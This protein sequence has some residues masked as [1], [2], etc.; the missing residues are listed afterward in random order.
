MPDPNDVNTSPGDP[1]DAVIAEYVQQ[2]EAGQIPDREALLARYPELAERLREF[3]ADFDRLDRQAGELRLSADP[4]RT[5][6]VPGPVME[7]QRVRYFGDYELL[8]VIAHGG[9]GVVYKARQMSLN[10]VVALKMILRGELTTERDVARFRAEAEAAA[11]LDHPHIV[12]IYEVGEHDGLQYYSMRYV[13][14]A[15]LA[16][17]PRT[18]SRSEAR[19]LAAVAGAVHHAHRRGVLHRDLKPSNIL[20]NTA[21][22]P[23]VA[24]FGLAKRVDADRSLTE[25][26]VI[27]GTPRYMAPEQAAGRKDLTVAV[28]VY[29][30]GVVLYERLTGHTPFTGETVLELLRQA[31]EEEPPRPSSICPGL[32]RDLE[33]I[34]LKCLE[35]D[36]SKRYGSAEALQDDLERWLRG[37]PIKARPVGQAER[38]WRWCRRNPVVAGLSAGIVVALLAVTGISVALAVQAR[39]LTEKAQQLTEVERE[40]RQRAERSE[41]D[42]QETLARSLIRPL[43]GRDTLS[44]Q[45]AEALW[46]L[47]Q[48]PGERLWLRFLVEA[49]RTPLTTS[50][51]S[52]RAES[53]WIAAVGLDAEKR[54]LVED[55]L[56]Q[57][58]EAADLSENQRLDLARAA[59]TLG[60][61][62]TVISKQMLDILIEGLASKDKSNGHN[63]DVNLLIEFTQRL[64]P[65]TATGILTQVL[66]KETNGNNRYLLTRELATVAGRMESDKA[67]RILTQALEKEK[68][69]HAW[70]RSFLFQ[71]LAEAAERVEPSKAARILIQALE[72][73]TDGSGCLELS[74]SLTNVIKRMELAEAT[75]ISG[76]AASILIQAIEK[77]TNS[78]HRNVLAQGLAK[79][80]GRMEPLEAVRVSRQAVNIFARALEKEPN[81]WGLNSLAVGLA[82]VAARIDSREAERLSGQAAKILTGELEKE[83]NAEARQDLARGLGAVAG[84]MELPTAARILTQALEQ[85]KDG[86]A[87]FELAGNLANLA[88]RMEPSE[89]ARVRGQAVSILTSALEKKSSRNPSNPLSEDPAEHRFWYTEALVYV[90][91]RMQSDRAARVL[92]E[93]LE[94]EKD[95][96]V[97][98]KLARGLA[99][100]AEKLES[101]SAAQVLRQAA[102]V[103]TTALVKDTEANARLELA[104]SLAAV[105]GRMEPDKAAR[106]LTQALEKESH[107]S[108]RNALVRGLSAASRRLSRAEADSVCQ[109]VMEKLLQALETEKDESERYILAGAVASLLSASDYVDASRVLAEL[110]FACCSDGRMNVQ[111]FIGRLIVMEVDADG[112]DVPLDTFLTSNS[113]SEVSRRSV[114]AATALGLASVTPLTSLPAL[115]SVTEPLACRLS[116]Q[117][118][119][120]LLKMP[121]CFGVARKVIL[122]H[123][124]NRYG[125]VFAN[126]WEF[127]RF[128]QEQHLDLD[129]LSPPKRPKRP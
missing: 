79:L 71:G 119:V 103:L 59:L 6:D 47:A 106:I 17:R 95:S 85:E 42:L 84:R 107:S 16:R 114:A 8:E 67:M 29:S 81:A 96:Q 89:A 86:V 74:G 99:V 104:D 22:V 78:Y 39:Q 100:T 65:G 30:L 68:G 19:L 24:D 28:D 11:N 112:I 63:K 128:A 72:K 5:T 58:L 88:G 102:N 33:T 126:H 77:D 60:D 73:E 120:E 76:Q 3:F 25:S 98:S 123:L 82:D 48:Q 57:R 27:V 61:L 92:T 115:P 36:P 32:D 26:G 13:E 122:K 109:P 21:G 46:E 105:T 9:M 97:R 31:R 49:M 93:T 117:D 52:G 110:A 23:L 12:P 118:L 101:H 1:L 64:E 125:R 20:V 127:V 18:D 94:K 111:G 69:K 83:T 15:S 66:E 75:R 10:R 62:D 7:F 80:A 44:H 34:C 50:Q 54:K 2:V 91:E 124:G 90:A 14:G 51:L 40:G 45:E 108:V 70:D 113:R 53:A 35:K 41:D 43:Q 87:C 38:L 4:N 121:T 129:L 116:T 55:L 56:V 37:E